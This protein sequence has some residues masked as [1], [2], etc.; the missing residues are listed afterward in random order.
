MGG[1]FEE[2]IAKGPQMMDVWG[3]GGSP[4]TDDAT[5]GSLNKSDG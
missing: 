3:K 5:S 4:S 1:S 2:Y